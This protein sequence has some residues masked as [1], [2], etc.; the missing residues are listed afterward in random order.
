MFLRFSGIMDVPGENASLWQQPYCSS[1]FFVEWFSNTVRLN[2][3]LTVC[4]RWLWVLFA[5]LMYSLWIVLFCVLRSKAKNLFLT[6]FL[7][8]VLSQINIPCKYSLYCGSAK[9]LHCPR[10]WILFWRFLSLCFAV[11]KWCRKYP[12]YP[13]SIPPK[14]FLRIVL[15]IFVCV[16]MRYSRENQDTL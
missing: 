3:F 13:H 9:W 14:L 1:S 6:L 16:F 11:S 10:P 4:L 15:T 7:W 2:C 12:L 8:I 5:S